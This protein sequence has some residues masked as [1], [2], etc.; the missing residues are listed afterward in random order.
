MAH[1]FA[2]YRDGYLDLWRKMTVT[3]LADARKQVDLIRKHA[4]V[5][6]QVEAATGV[7]WF[8]VGVIH[9]REAGPQDVG[10][11]KCILHNGQAIVGTGR[12]ST[13][14][15]IG[16]GPFATWHEAAVDALKQEGF[17]GVDWKND[18]I[19]RV[20]FFSEKFNGFG[21]RS[22]SKNI[23]SP[24]LWGGTSVQKRGKYVRDGVYDPYTMDPQIGTMAL[25]RVIMDETGEGFSPP[26]PVVPA[27]TPTVEPAPS[28]P[29]A[30]QLSIDPH[31]QVGG[32]LNLI[33]TVIQAV[34][35]RKS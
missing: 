19:A 35:K 30:S 9:L 6:K 32:L 7:P 29:P 20:A 33:Y 31:K 10:R 28:V 3:K 24:Y 18:G 8:V 26:A 12:K 15:P 22:P 23:P 25:L 1:T 17:I 2:N 21:Y 34:F 5:Y 11:W 4:S 16:V 13:I 14:V 27:P